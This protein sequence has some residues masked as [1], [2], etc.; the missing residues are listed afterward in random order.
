M[1][2]TI[3][4]TL[5]F[6]LFTVIKQVCGGKLIS[7]QMRSSQGSQ[8]PH[9]GSVTQIV[10]EDVCSTEY[11]TFFSR[12][13]CQTSAPSSCYLRG[14]SPKATGLALTW[15]TGY[16]DEE[17]GLDL[18]AYILMVPL[19]NGQSEI[20]LSLGRNLNATGPPFVLKWTTK[21]VCQILGSALFAET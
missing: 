18:E 4:L 11:C 16:I 1:D 19:Y 7:T 20:I 10:Y 15:L 9:I 12:N 5:S 3:L 14:L 2:N 6:A 8:L 13:I 21:R 17:C